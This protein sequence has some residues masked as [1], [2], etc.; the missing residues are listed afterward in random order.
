MSAIYK[1]E[2]A[3]ITPPPLTHSH[4]PSSNAQLHTLRIIDTKTRL[5]ESLPRDEDTLSSRLQVMLYH[6]LLSDLVTLNPPYDFPALWKKLG[7]R[8]AQNFSTAFLVEAKLISHSD[9]FQVVCLDDLA[10]SWHNLVACSNISSVD[11][12]SELVYR[13]QPESGKGKGKMRTPAVSQSDGYDNNVAKVENTS[14]NVGTS[15]LADD[16]GDLALQWA[17]QRSFDRS[18]TSDSRIG[19]K[20]NVQLHEL[21]NEIDQFKIIGRKKVSYDGSFL[22]NHITDIFRWWSGLRKP[23]GVPIE[24]VRRCYTCEY[25]SDCEWREEK[26][27]ES[28]AGVQSSGE[29]SP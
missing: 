2:S 14:G 25:C 24:L 16:P 20:S 1:N 5:N 4:L 19:E 11:P 21:K 13:L 29:A 22:D 18:D 10:T 3:S 9:D 17:I 28:G 26:A 7:L 12:T 8:S 6:R 27:K 15:A 23:R